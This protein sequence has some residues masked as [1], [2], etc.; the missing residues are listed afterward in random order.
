VPCTL[1][2]WGFGQ[3]TKRFEAACWW[4]T[5][6]LPSCVLWGRVEVNRP[7]PDASW[8]LPRPRARFH[9][10]LKP[11]GLG[12]S[13]KEGEIVGNRR[14]GPQETVL[15][16]AIRFEVAVVSTTISI[17][18][19]PAP[20]VRSDEFHRIEQAHTRVSIAQLTQF[21]P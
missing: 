21:K 12:A 20:R 9:L 4:S 15:T 13:F 18:S 7:A 2:D 1:A 11:L 8:T 14:G 16:H 5:R 3:A 17:E 6:L 19:N 10:N